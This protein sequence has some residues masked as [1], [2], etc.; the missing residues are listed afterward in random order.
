MEDATHTTHTVDGGT[1][2]H[3]VWRATGA[4][5]ASSMTGWIGMYARYDR[6]IQTADVDT[7]VGYIE[8]DWGVATT[9]T[10]TQQPT[11]TATTETAVTFQQT[12]TVT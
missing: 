6:L 10:Y 8:T 7:L 11:V 1:D 3:T 9:V 2:D 5:S 12:V 4:Q